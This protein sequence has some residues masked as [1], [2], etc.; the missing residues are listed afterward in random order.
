MLISE[1]IRIG[2][3]YSCTQK[4][5]APRYK[6]HTVLFVAGAPYGNLSSICC[7]I[8]ATWNL[9]TLVFLGFVGSRRPVLVFL[10]LVFYRLP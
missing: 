6:Y 9:R 1:E 3:K 2:I 5:G 10:L 8:L 4:Y 7:F